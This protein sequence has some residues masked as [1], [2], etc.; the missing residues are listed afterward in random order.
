MEAEES[1]EE[2]LSQEIGQS[3]ISFLTNEPEGKLLACDCCMGGW[4]GALM[5]RMILILDFNYFPSDDSLLSQNLDDSDDLPCFISTPSNTKNEDE[6]LPRTRGKPSSSSSSS[7]SN[8]FKRGDLAWAKHKDTW[9]P[10]VV[11]NVYKARRCATIIWTD[12][13]EESRKKNLSK[14]FKI[15][16]SSLRPWSC[17]ERKAMVTEGE[18]LPGTRFENAVGMLDNYLVKRAVHG[19]EMDIFEYL[20]SVHGH[21]YSLL[22]CRASGERLEAEEDATYSPDI[23]RRRKVG[24]EGPNHDRRDNEIANG[25]LD[26]LPDSQDSGVID[27]N[28]RLDTENGNTLDET[29]K[30]EA[31]QDDLCHVRRKLRMEIGGPPSSPETS[32]RIEKIVDF[33]SSSEDCRQRLRGI[34]ED[35][36]KSFLKVFYEYRG[37]RHVKDAKLNHFGPLKSDEDI[38]KVLETLKRYY[39]EYTGKATLKAGDLELLMDVYLPEALAYAIHVLEGKSLNVA[40][41][42]I[43]FGVSKPP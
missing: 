20:S 3:G 6:K 36:E 31:D 14:G 11:K 34:H 28:N 30:E 27:N 4:E 1:S 12:E 32:S 40:L 8:A 5:L 22:D 7:S 17:A 18:S 42:E 26:D 33:I 13:C 41:R 29:L 16:L 25:D 10:A 2:A 24:P 15:Q 43:W 23:K 39:C 21:M 37:G 9:W 19:M 35:E 38:D